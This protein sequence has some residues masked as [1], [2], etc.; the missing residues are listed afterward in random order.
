MA[1]R[2][3]NSL[4]TLLGQVNALYPNRS[5]ASDGTIAD[6]RHRAQGAASD[7]NINAYGVVTALD[8]TH[9]PAHGLDIQQLADKLVATN[10]PRIKYV[11]ANRRIWYSGRW[12]PYSGSND[13]H[14]NHVHISVSTSPNLYD[15]GQ[16]WYIDNEDMIK[17]TD[18]EYGRWLKLAQQVR[19][20]PQGFGRDEFRNAAVGK[21]WLQAIEILSD[22][23]E[24]D[25]NYK[26][27]RIGEMAFNDKWDQQI[28]GLRD[29]LNK[30]RARAAE[31]ADRPTKEAFHE[32]EDKLVA[33]QTQ[34]QKVSDSVAG[35]PTTPKP[36]EPSL[37]MRL[38]AKLFVKD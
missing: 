23:P 36:Q 19:H 12:S 22:A 14:T 7:H 31:L 18:N 30:L 10:D 29:E 5:K 21:T 37:L 1:W 4:L 2:A 33:C 15:N 32:L 28:Y 24:A 20:R 11:I 26:F 13:P 35:L 16:P 27:A 25:D 9:D 17:D 38:L 34:A 3:A 6:E 8:I